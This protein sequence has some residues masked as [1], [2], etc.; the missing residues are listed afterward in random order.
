[1]EEDI[2][3]IEGMY[4]IFLWVRDCL[5]FRWVLWALEGWSVFCF[6]EEDLAPWRFQIPTKILRDQYTSPIRQQSRALFFLHSV[7]VSHFNGHSHYSCGVQHRDFN[8]FPPVQKHLRVPVIHRR[9]DAPPGGT[10]APRKVLLVTPP[11]QRGFF[12]CRK[13]LTS[14]L[15]DLFDYILYHLGASFLTSVGSPKSSPSKLPQWAIENPTS[16]LTLCLLL[17]QFFRMRR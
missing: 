6:S 10:V 8:H 5:L 3:D 13:F 2:W 9:G 16:T 17:C 14:N 1:M 12:L 15:R 7:H 11:A 4:L